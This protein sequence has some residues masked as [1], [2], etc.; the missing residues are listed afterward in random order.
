DVDVASRSDGGA[1]IFITETSPGGV[2]HIEQIL[3]AIHTDPDRFEYA[4][5]QVLRFCPAERQAAVLR[6]LLAWSVRGVDG[7]ASTFSHVRSARSLEDSDRCRCELTDLLSTTGLDASRTTVVAVMNRVLRPGSS[8][9]T[10]VTM[11]LLNRARTR[12]QKRLGV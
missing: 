10:D 11:H 8:P 3:S 5:G 2:G 7:W 6:E 1:D 9:R 12:L 4:F